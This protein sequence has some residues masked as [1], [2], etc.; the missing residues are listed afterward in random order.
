LRALVLSRTGA[1]WLTL[2]T[3]GLGLG[4][5][6]ALLTVYWDVAGKPLPF[7]DDR[8]LASIW[9]SD[10]ERDAPHLELS[11][12]DV[13]AIAAELESLSDYLA[14]RTRGDPALAVPAVER[15]VA[16]VFG[17][18]PLSR[19]RT[20]GQLVGEK[21]AQPRLTA[22]VLGSFA[23]SALLVAGVGL[24]GVL[25]LWTRRRRVDLGVRLALGALPRALVLQV[26]RRSAALF[27]AGAG[28]GLAIVPAARA[29]RTDPLECLREE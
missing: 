8:R 1:G 16:E 14:V 18:L 19:V 5:G 12:Q 6:A 13:E 9:A 4:V 29:A 2:A 24:Y 21:L 15:A 28:A 11:L 22:A 23:A 10:P 20:T 27:T 3:L 17:G 7:P 25:A 26:A